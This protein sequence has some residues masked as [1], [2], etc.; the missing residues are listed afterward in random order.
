LTGLQEVAY[1]GLSQLKDKATKEIWHRRIAHRSMNQQTVESITKS[2]KDF[3]LGEER[4]SVEGIC[5][6]CAEGKQSRESLTGERTKSAELLDTIHSDVCGPMATTGLMGEHYF[7]T[8]IDEQSGRIAILLLVQKSEVFERFKQY[9][10][11]VEL[12]TGKR[13]RSLR[14]DGGGKY[15]GNI[16]QRYLTEYCIIQRITL[17]YTPEHNGIAEGANRTIM[18]MVR[19]M[20]FDS[21][22]GKEFWGFAA[23]TAV[24]I[25]N[26]L[27][28]SAHEGKTPFEIWFGVPPSIGHLRVFGCIAYRHIPSAVRRKLDPKG[29]KCRMIGYKEESGSRVYRVYDE[30]TKQVLVTRDVVFDETTTIKVLQQDDGQAGVQLAGLEELADLQVEQRFATGNEGQE[31]GY[32]SGDEEEAGSGRP[33]PPIDPEE[34]NGPAQVYDQETITVRPP[35]V[36]M[37]IAP[38]PDCTG[39]TVLDRSSRPQRTRPLPEM[40]RPAAWQAFMAV[41]EEP[42]TLQEALA[43]K[44]GPAWKAAGESELDSLQKNGTWV[45]EDAPPDRNIVGSRWLFKRKENGRFKVPLVAKG[46]SQEPGIDFQETFAPVAKFTTL[47]VLLALIAENDWELHSM[48]VKTAILNGILEEEIYM[49]CPEGVI[50]GSRGSKVCRLIKA[51]YGL[52]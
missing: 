1:A 22:L 26:R 47:R 46:F 6:I 38:Q 25:I 31:R 9:K 33:L 39:Q 32:S 18:E 40:F 50:E 41:T 3:N 21:A 51:I 23:L 48:D 2:V 43:G 29:R 42:V 36:Q 19:C 52:R 12:E 37:N 14:C 8:F 13:I 24:H 30:T 16:F 15:T 11:K 49:E 28:S 27:P 4:L 17:A 20:I 45:V 44:D 7:A 34:G 35:Q 10:A 5:A